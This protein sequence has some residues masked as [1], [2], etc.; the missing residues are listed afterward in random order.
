MDIW[1]SEE[2]LPF[3]EALASSVRIRIIERL[4]EGEANIKELATHIGISSAMMSSHIAKLE[5]AGFII[6]TRSKQHG[7]VCVLV[8]TWYNL[9]MPTHAY[10]HI[11]HYDISLGVGQ[12]VKADVT[13]TCGLATPDNIIGGYDSAVYFHDPKR[14]EAQLVWFT[15]GYVEYEIPNYIPPNCK[16]LALEISAEMC[17]EYPDIR[18]NW[19]SEINI[20][21]NGKLICPWI[22]PGD[23]GDRPGKYTPSWWLSA[24]YGVLKCYEINQEGVFLNKERKSKDTIENF[25]LDRDHW[26]LRFEVSKEH[27]RPG[28]LT[29]FGES[30][31]DYP[32]SIQVK[33]DY[34]KPNISK[35]TRS[36]KVLIDSP[37][38][39]SEK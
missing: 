27:M 29:I 12:F 10:H 9:R 33:V 4:A 14:F 37:Q 15:D 26:T 16:A 30:F 6:T 36:N 5:Q 23:F 22:S 38:K 24:Q 25:D 39:Y 3:F 19:Q 21:L 13:P 18:N 11:Q 31:G 34:E 17:S 1:V 28:G 20:Y 32:Q 7:K 2:N 8:S 35:S